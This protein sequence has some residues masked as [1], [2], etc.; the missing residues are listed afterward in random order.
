[1]LELPVDLPPTVRIIIR[2]HPALLPPRASKRQKLHWIPNPVPSPHHEIWAIRRKLS[3]LQRSNALAIQRQRQTEAGEET[4][5]HQAREAGRM[6]RRRTE[7]GV[8]GG[9]GPERGGGHAH[10][11]KALSPIPLIGLTER[12]SDPGHDPKTGSNLGKSIIL[13]PIFLVST[14][15]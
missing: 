1:M 4:I 9:Q 12:D 14:I 7:K 2:Q 13:C 11:Q 5:M 3:K 8:Q 6:K 10:P 15:K